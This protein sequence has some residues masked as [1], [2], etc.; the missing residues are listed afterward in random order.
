MSKRLPQRS[1][2]KPLVYYHLV[3]EQQAF[4]GLSLQV[5]AI[6]PAR[7]NVIGSDFTSTGDLA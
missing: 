3:T 5:P 6:T 1:P 2:G 7:F 4:P